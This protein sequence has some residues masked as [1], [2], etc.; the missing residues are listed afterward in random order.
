MSE[1]CYRTR[2]D[3]DEKDITDLSHDSLECL[4]NTYQML[5]VFDKWS[6]ADCSDSQRCG[7][8]W[9][10][11]MLWVFL[12]KTELFPFKRTFF[13]LENSLFSK[14][15]KNSFYRFKIIIYEISLSTNLCQSVSNFYMNLVYLKE[16]NNFNKPSIHARYIED[17]FI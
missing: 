14:Y 12:K 2:G 8:R 11:D 15:S 5:S 1:L 4:A 17:I 10:S 6:C 13:V 9:R 3:V 7:A 16:Y